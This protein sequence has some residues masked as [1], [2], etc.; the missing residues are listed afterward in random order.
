M[1][2]LYAILEVSPNASPE[3]IPAAYKSLVIAAAPSCWGRAG[4]R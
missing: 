2:T 1:E 3:T 4:I